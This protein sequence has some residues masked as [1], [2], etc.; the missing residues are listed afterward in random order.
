MLQAQRANND[1]DLR[2]KDLGRVWGY[3]SLTTVLFHL[4]RL[5]AAGLVKMQEH[6][7]ICKWRAVEKAVNPGS[8]FN[9]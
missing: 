9:D 3:Q 4:R 6:G 8:R 2:L 1:F 5:Q 7:R